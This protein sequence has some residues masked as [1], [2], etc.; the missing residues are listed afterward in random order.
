MT[1]SRIISRSNWVGEVE[2]FP[3]WI[4]FISRMLCTIP[5][6][7]CAPGAGRQRGSGGATAPA[8][9]ISLAVRRRRTSE[10]G[11]R[12]G[13]RDG[14]EQNDGT[15]QLERTALVRKVSSSDCATAPSSARSCGRAPS[16]CQ[17]GRSHRRSRVVV[18]AAPTAHARAEQLPAANDGSEHGEGCSST[19]ANLGSHEDAVEGSSP[20]G[21]QT[22]AQEVLVL[23]VVRHQ[24]F[25]RSFR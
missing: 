4:F 10:V 25:F 23:G 13:G 6:N 21:G 20:V 7:T 24:A 16:A 9:A 18:I 2:I 12:C 17:Q 3:S 14:R 15:L 22:R 1:S 19:K 8:L 11:R 5:N